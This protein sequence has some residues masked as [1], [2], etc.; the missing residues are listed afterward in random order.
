[1]LENL[2]FYINILFFLTVLA[3]LLLFFKGTNLNNMVLAVCLVWVFFLGFLSFNG[4]FLILFTTPP[5]II[6]A[7]APPMLAII[8]LFALPKGRVLLD[9]FDGK[10]LTYLH[11][12]RIPV[13][14]ILLLLFLNGLVPQIM[15]FE[16]RNFDILAGVTAPLVAYFGYTKQKLGKSFL[17]FWNAIC[18]VLLFNIIINSA[19][20]TPT[21]FQMFAFNQPNIGV[22][23]FPFIWLPA[24]IVPVVL[25]SH[26]VCLRQLLKK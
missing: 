7:V 3:T 25:L 24:F 4:F 6:F 12:V 8:L 20:S 2:P 26:L 11:T 23:Y 13:E 1:M 16:G 15:T 21:D 18:L 22:L 19:L 14:I 10:W 9:S 17:I 5:R